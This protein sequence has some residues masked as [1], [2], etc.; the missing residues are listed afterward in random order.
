MSEYDLS[1]TPKDLLTSKKEGE[2]SL[3]VQPNSQAT[4]FGELSVAQKDPEF[5]INAQYNNLSDVRVI[6]V[7]G[8]TATAA[9]GQFVASSGTNAAGLAA[10]FTD[11][12]IISKVG[13][14]SE[15]ILTA[16]FDTPVADCL[17]Q[18]GAATAMDALFF[19]YNDLTFG[20]FYEH[21]GLVLIEELATQFHFDQIIID[22]SNNSWVADNWSREAN[23]LGIKCHVVVT[24]GAFVTDV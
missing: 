12:Q 18:A 1:S 16:M 10:I 9:N 7:S 5:Q 8:A 17:Q 19:G 4:A 15:I 21:N 2:R 23:E 20:V 6:E 13:Q 3:K 11:R 14:G 24:Q 22:S